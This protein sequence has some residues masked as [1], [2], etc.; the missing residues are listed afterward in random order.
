M[1]T[2]LP[3]TIWKKVIIMHMRKIRVIN[4]FGDILDYIAWYVLQAHHY[5]DDEFF[6]LATECATRAR[7][8]QRGY[9]QLIADME[10]IDLMGGWGNP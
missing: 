4:H 3:G 1:A 10:H 9:E 2:S 8:A 5:L 6:G 7:D